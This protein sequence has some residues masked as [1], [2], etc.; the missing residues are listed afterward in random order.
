[1]RT[2]AVTCGHVRSL[3]DTCAT[4]AVTCEYLEEGKTEQIV[5]ILLCFFV[6]FALMTGRILFAYGL[7][8]CT[9][10]A[11]M[12]VRGDHANR[13]FLCGAI[14]ETGSPV[15]MI[16]SH[17]TALHGPLTQARIGAYPM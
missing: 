4:R 14:E 9:L 13:G 1:M 12:V 8:T 15:H 7:A 6:L 2:R 10:Q 17:A 16:G 3:R 5:T 11:S